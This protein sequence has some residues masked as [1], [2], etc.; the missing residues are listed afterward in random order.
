MKRILFTRCT[1]HIIFCFLF[2]S[3][4]QICKAQKL[5]VVKLPFI[6]S[7]ELLLDYQISKVL[8]NR[9]NKEYIGQVNKGM[10]NKK[11]DAVT[12]DSLVKSL[13]TFIGRSFVKSNP[14]DKYILSVN[15]LWISEQ[16]RMTKEIGFLELQFFKEQDNVMMDYGICSKEVEKGGMDVTKG[17]GKRIT[18]AIQECLIEFNETKDDVV[19]MG[20]SATKDLNV[21]YY[22]FNANHL[23]EGFYANESDLL[24]GVAVSYGN[25]TMKEKGKKHKSYI[26]KRASTKKKIK[27]LFYSDGT[28][29][30]LNVVAFQYNA[31]S[32]VKCENRGR[33]LF[34]RSKFSDPNASAAFGA[35]GAIA[36][37]KERAYILDTKTGTIKHLK[38]EYMNQLLEP[39]NELITEYVKLPKKV[40]DKL[41]LINKLNELE[42]DE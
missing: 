24:N 23:K 10:M 7:D 35:I 9:I 2:I 41:I 18:K 6:Q 33:F 20:L 19:P 12:E 21:E 13:S 17:H 39:H 38:D 4:T 27:D 37:N 29:L 1:Q 32:F 42:E 15:K 30:Y 34:F 26:I 14:E 5:H 25:I 8:D 16:I 31:Q 22:D 3:L 11:R 28:D 36:S 40:D